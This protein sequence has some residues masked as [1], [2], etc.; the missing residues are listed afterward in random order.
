MPIADLEACPHEDILAN[1]TCRPE[2]I[3]KEPKEHESLV[4]VAQFFLEVDLDP[5]Y[6]WAKLAV[7]G[8]KGSRTESNAGASRSRTTHGVRPS[9]GEKRSTSRKRG[10]L[11]NEEAMLHSCST[12]RIV[13]KM[14][15][16]SSRGALESTHLNATPQE[17]PLQAA[18]FQFDF[19]LAPRCQGT[20]LRE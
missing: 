18:E 15:A 14:R 8:E 2:R 1:S 7:H 5:S 19:L 16:S 20:A 9:A 10:T 11:D 12:P 3:I 4:T 6:L 17:R 13:E